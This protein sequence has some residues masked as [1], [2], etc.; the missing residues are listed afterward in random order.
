M[1]RLSQK[2]RFSIFARIQNRAD[3]LLGYARQKFWIDIFVDNRELCAPPFPFPKKSSF[4]NQI[5]VLLTIALGNLTR[6]SK[7]LGRLDSQ[8]T[9]SPCYLTQNGRRCKEGYASYYGSNLE[10]TYYHNPKSKPRCRRSGTMK[11]P[12]TSG[13]RNK[14]SLSESTYLF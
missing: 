6:N 12:E 1:K 7:L 5:I 9:N 4:P 8:K 13:S 11:V 10:A 3:W 2:E 14:R